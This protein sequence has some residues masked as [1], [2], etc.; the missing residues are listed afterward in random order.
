MDGCH[1]FHGV[2]AVEADGFKTVLVFKSGKGCYR[3]VTLFYLNGKGLFLFLVTGD[4]AL[5]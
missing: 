4:D 5:F 2:I 1:E 3:P